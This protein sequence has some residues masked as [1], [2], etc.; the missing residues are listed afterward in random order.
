MTPSLLKS[1]STYSKT[2]KVLEKEEMRNLSE[3]N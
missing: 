3:S 1:S 2:Y